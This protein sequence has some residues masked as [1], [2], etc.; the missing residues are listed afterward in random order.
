MR[1]H[2]RPVRGQP[3]GMVGDDRLHRLLHGREVVAHTVFPEP[4]ALDGHGRV[5][6]RGRSLLDIGEEG[7]PVLGSEAGSLALGEGLLAPL[8]LAE[9]RGVVDEEIRVSDASSGNRHR[10]RE[11]PPIGVVRATEVADV[12]ARV[13]LVPGADVGLAAV[14]A[15]LQPLHRVLRRLRSEVEDVRVLFPEVIE[16]EDAMTV[17]GVAAYADRAAVE[18]NVEHPQVLISEQ[19]IPLARHLVGNLLDGRDGLLVHPEEAELTV[20]RQVED[21]GAQLRQRIKHQ[22][23]ALFGGGIV[24]FPALIAHPRLSAVGRAMVARIQ[25][26]RRGLGV[27]EH[28]HARRL[29][30]GADLS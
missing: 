17:F 22:R 11:L 13:G 2:V 15:Y 27:Q 20:G 8:A 5:L 21:V 26:Y 16:R 30:S 10:D 14:E 19:F 7:R 24:R 12:A 6:Q 9:Q 29:F 3:D 18:A 28:V 4:A 1:C 25:S 23:V